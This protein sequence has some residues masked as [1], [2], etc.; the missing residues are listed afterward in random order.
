MFEQLVV[1]PAAKTAVERQ[2]CAAGIDQPLAWRCVG[3]SRLQCRENDSVVGDLTGALKPLLIAIL[4]VTKPEKLGSLG[5]K[6][7]QHPSFTIAIRVEPHGRVARLDLK[8]R[9]R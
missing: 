9:N 5:I 6:N 4:I 7:F 1:Q 2:D 3:G 8:G